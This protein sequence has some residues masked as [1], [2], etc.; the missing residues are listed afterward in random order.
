VP[1]FDSVIGWIEAK[2]Q[3]AGPE[4]RCGMAKATKE[5]SERGNDDVH[6]VQDGT[7][8]AFCLIELALAGPHWTA[9][10]GLVLSGEGCPGDRRG[11]SC[12]TERW[13]AISGPG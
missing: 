6:V 3:A 7:C 9:V 8:D 11:D 10:K 5:C 1:C 2:T 12:P 13:R 4:C